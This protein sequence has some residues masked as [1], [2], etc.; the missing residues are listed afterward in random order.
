M[1]DELVNAAEQHGLYLQLCLL[2][3][4]LYMNALNDPAKPEYSRAIEDASKLLRYAVARWGYSTSVA[5]WEYWNEMNPGLP[6]DHF[7]TAAG[8]FLEQIDPYHHLRT[9]STW[10]PSAKDA[11]HPKL[12]FADVHFYLR[13]AD[14]GR[15]RDEV[16]AALE[17]ARWLREQAPN[18]PAHLGEFG[19]ANDK[20]MPTEEMNTSKELLDFHNGLWASALSGASGTAMFWWWER[21]DRLNAYS[22]YQPL[23][24]FVRDV[25]WNGGD[26]RKA[27]VSTVEKSLHPIGLQAGRKAW[28]WVFNEAASWSRVV[29]EQ[30]QP[31]EVPNASVTLEGMPDGT[32]HVQWWDTRTGTPVRTDEVTATGNVLHLESP[33]FSHDIACTVSSKTGG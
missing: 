17:R 16:D 4:D 30:T 5:A 29:I 32:Y 26:V 25:P 8:E 33:S 15:L 7:Y 6:T 18:K 14:K 10:G 23:A 3:R 21:L 22:H 19:L 2:T 12:D 28:L 27:S 9:T 24:S 20:W 11:R 31:K 1:L 13:P